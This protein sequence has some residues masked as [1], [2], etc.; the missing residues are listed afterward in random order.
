M[1]RHM[2]VSGRHMYVPGRHM[3]VPKGPLPRDAAV[4]INP[5]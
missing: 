2:Y 3:Y 5:R 1:C 4:M